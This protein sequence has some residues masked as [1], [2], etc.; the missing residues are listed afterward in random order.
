MGSQLGKETT[1]A[2][3][4]EGD[5]TPEGCCS[6][7][8][9]WIITLCVCNWLATLVFPV[10]FQD[11]ISGCSSSSWPSRP[12]ARYPVSAAATRRTAAGARASPSKGWGWP[13][14]SWP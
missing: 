2:M 7:A 8:N 11:I 5:Q 10:I 12:S 9:C 1:L 3:R 4:P 13:S 14:W 6:R